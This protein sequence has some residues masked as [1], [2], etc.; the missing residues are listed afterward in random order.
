[1]VVC[2]VAQEIVAPHFDYIDGKISN[3]IFSIKISYQ[4]LA[5]FAAEFPPM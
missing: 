2:H 3:G 4:N 1:M 5:K